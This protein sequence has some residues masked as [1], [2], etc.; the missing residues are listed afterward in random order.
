MRIGNPIAKST[1][2]G[3]LATFGGATVAAYGTDFID[4]LP[5]VR[6]LSPDI[7]DAA[8]GGA[9][10]TLGM[11]VKGSDPLAKGLKAFGFTLAAARAIKAVQRHFGSLSGGMNNFLPRTIGSSSQRPLMLGSAQP[12]AQP[13]SVFENARVAV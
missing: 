10:L 11:A 4:G 2:Y 7:Q 3:D 13:Q 8:I 6:D 9:A 12:Q 5:V 1:L